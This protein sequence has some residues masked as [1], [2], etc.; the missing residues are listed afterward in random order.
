MGSIEDISR[1][2]KK[3]RDD[4]MT[5]QDIAKVLQGR[6]NITIWDYKNATSL[7][8][9]TTRNIPKSTYDYNVVGIELLPNIYLGIRL[10]VV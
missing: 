8:S 10:L 9:G 7:F 5:V 6:E 4:N 1:K 3:E 2:Q